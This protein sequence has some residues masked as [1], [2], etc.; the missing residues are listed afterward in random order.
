MFLFKSQQTQTRL[1]QQHEHTRYQKHEIECEFSQNKCK[2]EYL[3]SIY[4][5]LFFLFS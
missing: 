5:E 2:P 3:G 1:C 4:I